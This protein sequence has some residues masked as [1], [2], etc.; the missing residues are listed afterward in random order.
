MILIN[1]YV[2]GKP[3]DCYRKGKEIKASGV[4]N[5]KIHG[6]VTYEQKLFFLNTH[7]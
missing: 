3:L 5:Y 1:R 4:E 7:Y 6:I 2:V